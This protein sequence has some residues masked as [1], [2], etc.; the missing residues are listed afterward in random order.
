M[1]IEYGKEFWRVHLETSDK[2]VKTLRVEYES[3]AMLVLKL[4]Q[5]LHHISSV[6]AKSLPL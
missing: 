3:M 4:N 2:K 6:N 5:A 1:A